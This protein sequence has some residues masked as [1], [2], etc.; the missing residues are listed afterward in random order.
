M[1]NTPVQWDHWRSFIAVA[2]EGSLSGAA[3]ALRLTQPT[4]GRHIDLLE[5]A[6]GAGL[7][8]RAPHGMS[9]TDLGRDL[10]P[11]ARA[12]A[13]AA[14]ALERTASA[15]LDAG[16]GIVRLT[17][18]EVVG[19]EILPGVLSPLLAAHPGLEVELVLSNRNEDLLR[20]EADLAVRMARPAQSGLVARRIAVVR[21]GLYAHAR[22]LAAHGTP[23]T[24]A[25]LAGH[26]LIGPDRDE[27]PLAAMAA[28]GLDRRMLR[29]RCD[30]E[31]AQLNALRA[32]LGIGAA[33]AGIARACPD[34][35]PVLQSQFDFRLDCW[36][37]MHEDLRAS[38][39]VRLLFDHLA[40]HLPD[41]LAG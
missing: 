35:R 27:G 8:L 30:R 23:Q 20:R 13:A 21:I 14:A 37:A 12:M 32:G 1:I 4:V 11:E 3:R 18:S 28:A 24:P 38:A 36:L 15:P 16:R 34:L 17:A 6:V 41:A 40:A 31:A 2:E 5:R 22:Y 33:Q 39:R 9:L 10:L 19:A 7:F 26:L 29:F 25:D